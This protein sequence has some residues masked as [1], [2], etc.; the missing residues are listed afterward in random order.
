MKIELIVLENGKRRIIKDNIRVQHPTKEIV[1][2]IVR[3]V[4]KKHLGLDVYVY[5]SQH[6]IDLRPYEESLYHIIDGIIHTKEGDCLGNFVYY[7][8]TDKLFI[9]IKK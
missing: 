8:F 1:G 3:Q 6:S 5:V 4:I 2:S 7:T 9:Y